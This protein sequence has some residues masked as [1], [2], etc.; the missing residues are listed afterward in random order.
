MP[1]RVAW[2]ILRRACYIHSLY[3]LYTYIIVLHPIFADVRA[4]P[5]GRLHLHPRRR[6]RD[7]R[8]LLVHTPSCV[9]HAMAA[10][11]YRRTACAWRT[12]YN[13]RHACASRDSVHLAVLAPCTRMRTLQQTPGITGE[14]CACARATYTHSGAPFLRCAVRRLSWPPPPIAIHS[15]RMDPNE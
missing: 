8:E 10:K 7:L 11:R 5:E 9:Q 13:L 15:F 6:Q 14:L 12:S 2:C 1:S 4:E 3:M